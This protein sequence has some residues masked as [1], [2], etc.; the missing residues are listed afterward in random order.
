MAT[1]GERQALLFLAA[2][3]L[4]GAGTRWYRS[5]RPPPED[6]GVNRQLSAL[7][8]AGR[9]SHAKQPKRK[10][11]RPAARVDTAPAPPP[12]PPLP[13][14]KIDLDVASVGTIETLP[15]VGPSLAKRIASN[16]DSSGAFGCLLAL[17]AVK[18]VGPAMLKRLDSLVTFSGFPREACSRGPPAPGGEDQGKDDDDGDDDQGKGRGRGRWER[19]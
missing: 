13:R 1:T 6:T 8:S 4:L 19:G 15:G 3:A 11:Q 16:R 17:D 7:D 10:R 2:V 5:R 9:F 12:L 18:G 14:E